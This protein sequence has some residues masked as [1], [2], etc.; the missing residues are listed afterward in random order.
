[1]WFDTNIGTDPSAS[2]AL[3]CA[4]KHPRIEVVGVS[5]SDTQQQRRLDEAYAVLEYAQAENVPV[6]LGENVSALS[7]DAA[8]PDDTITTGP[9]TNISRLVLDE[10]S[11]GRIH[12]AGGAFRAV[13][14]RGATITAEKN[15]STDKEATRIVLS[16][17]DDVCINAL[18]ASSALVL[19][20]EARTQIEDKH[21]FL[22]NRYDGFVE[23]L[24][25]QY[26]NVHSE[27]LMN[28]VLPLCDI[29]NTATI[30]REVIEFYIQPDGSFRRAYT[31]AHRPPSI[32]EV[33]D[34]PDSVPVP[35]VKHEVVRAVEPSH[36]L[37]ELVAT[38]T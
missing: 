9:L 38:L 14:Y 29:L 33:T 34:N 20:Q 21:P 19:T 37:G 26:G 11:L 18:E 23:Y 22:K 13:D 24:I 10:A 32:P 16:Q 17:Y 15:V 36:V 1:M 8:R 7:I 5:I 27:L 28:A 12:I 6:F 4:L 3:L 31:L 35:L 30:T 2:T 25:N